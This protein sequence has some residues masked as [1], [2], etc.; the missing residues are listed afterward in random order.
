MPLTVNK[1]PRDAFSGDLFNSLGDFWTRL[2]KDRNFIVNLCKGDSLVAAQT[3]LNL[4]ETTACLGRATIPA[5]HREHWFPLVIRESEADTGE[6]VNLYLGIKPMV[7]LGPQPVDTAYTPEQEFN[8]GGNALKHG[9]TSFP[10]H[11]ENFHS[12]ML[13]LCSAIVN[14]KATYLLNVDYYIDRSTVIF[15]LELNPFDFPDKFVIRQVLNSSGV[16]D[17]EL[18]LWASDVLIDR[19]YVPDHFGYLQKLAFPTVEYGAET[20]NAIL[21]LRSSGTSMALLKKNL[22]RMFSTPVV[23]SDNETVTDIYNSSSGQTYVITDKQAYGCRPEETLVAGMTRGLVLNQ[24]DFITDTLRFYS[25]LNPDKFQPAN[26]Y[27]IGQ[28]VSDVPR[29]ALPKGLISGEG[30]SAGLIVEW[31]DTDI[32][33]NGLDSNGHA[34]LSF[35][36]SAV[37]ETEAAY[38]TTVWLR[39]ERQ[40]ED[41]A[42]VMSPYLYSDASFTEGGTV[43]RLNPM[44]FFMKNCLN[45]NTSILVVDFNAIPE[46]IKSLDLLYELNRVTAAH[47][48]IFLVAKRSITEEAYDLGAQRVVLDAYL[49]TGGTSGTDGTYGTSGTFGVTYKPKYIGKKLIELQGASGTSGTAGFL[50]Y[51]D[52]KPICKRVPK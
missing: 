23:E 35:K 44:Q 33:F 27:T 17:R 37:P 11:S 42:A 40:N 46:Y 26:G 41:M 21:E 16:Q 6:G 9:F 43:G 34:R 13:T 25:K 4:L 50:T 31:A 39:C 49:G 29:L 28:F 2:Y 38:W 47:A 7:V 8:I 1:D 10:A 52:F 14:P 19:N 3:Y 5:L 45:S 20:T 24:G 48:L 30:L 12:G 22:G 15:K 51:M 36:V 32:I 18:V